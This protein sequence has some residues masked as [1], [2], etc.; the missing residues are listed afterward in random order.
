MSKPEWGTKHLCHSCGTKFYDLQRS[1]VIC[2]SCGVEVDRESPLKSRRSRNASPAK[3][4]P[5]EPVT[6]PKPVADDEGEDLNDD[7]LD[8]TDL[9]DADLGDDDLAD[10]SDDDIIEDTS[11]LGDDDMSDVVASKDDD[12]DR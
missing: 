6:K 7:D 3:P 4:V 12:D 8:D 9:D 5:L 11:E 2:P 1:P 10:D